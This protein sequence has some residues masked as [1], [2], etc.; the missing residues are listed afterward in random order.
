MSCGAGHRCS[1]DL[2]LLWLWHMP[3]ATALIRSLAWELPYALGV[4]LEKAKKQTKKRTWHQRIVPPTLAFFFF[5]LFP[6]F[7]A[8]NAKCLGG[9]SSPSHDH[10]QSEQNREKEKQNPPSLIRLSNLPPLCLFI[11]ACVAKSGVKLIE[12]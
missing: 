3:V 9:R 4:A 1:L 5:F 6:I 8:T 11:G 2:A 7:V 10:D 12:K